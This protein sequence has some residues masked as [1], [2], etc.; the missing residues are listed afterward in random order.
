M[1][2]EATFYRPIVFEE[3]LRTVWPLSCL[4]H[5]PFAFWLMESLKP[6]TLVELGTHTGNS[7]AALCQGAKYLNYEPSCFAFD[8]WQED[9]NTDLCGEEVYSN[10]NAYFA[11]EYGKF[12]KLIQKTF[13]EAA[14][15]FSDSSV[16]LLS[17]HGHHTY[18]AITENFNTWLPK[19]S[20]KGVI[21]VHDISEQGSDFGA[22]EFWNE[23]KARFRSFAFTHGHGLG[24]IAVGKDL[25]PGLKV[26]FDSDLKQTKQIQKFFS[27]IGSIPVLKATNRVL[28][29]IEVAAEPTSYPTSG[30]ENPLNANLKLLSKKI[31][32]LLSKLES[33]GSRYAGS[34]YW[35]KF[36]ENNLGST[37]EQAYENLEEERSWKK[38]VHRNLAQEIDEAEEKLEAL[39]KMNLEGI[40]YKMFV[41]ANLGRN[42]EDALSKLA[43]VGEMNLE[44]M[45]FKSFVQGHLAESPEAAFEKLK[46]L[47]DMNFEAQEY[48]SI[49]QRHFGSNLA[50]TKARLE[51]IIAVSSQH[52]ELQR[53]IN[54]R[55][56]GPGDISQKLNL[57]L[58]CYERMQSTGHRTVSFVNDKIGTIFR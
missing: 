1:Q 19:L 34:L 38:F 42:L 30:I 40:Q 57:L 12:A 18:E 41:Q 35:K 14:K 49:L 13:N 46:A 26:L 3:V 48:K 28:S 50:I 22:G 32:L 45:K 15:D 24:V 33:L 55:V 29:E 56:H 37:V 2:F 52:L 39:G 31:R 21:L 23:I 51:E 43:A 6:K 16:D 54:E 4:G 7:F 9:S 36:V 10:V 17:I 25:P 20:N 47:A 53:A 44:G 8:I 11:S 5:A 58:A 27:S